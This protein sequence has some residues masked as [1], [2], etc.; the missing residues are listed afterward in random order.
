MPSSASDVVLIAPG[1]SSRRV[2]KELWAYRELLWVLAARDIKVR[3]K[4]TVLGV[5]WVLLQPLLQ[6]TVFT[7][8]LGRIARLPSEGVPYA[9]FAYA[10]LLPWTFFSA[11]LSN[12][13]SSV[14]GSSQ[15]VTKVYFPRL[16]IPLSSVVAG[17]VDVAI[18]SVFLFGLL[19]YYE[20]AIG[21][22]ILVMAPLFVL[23][24]MTSFGVGAWLAALTVSYRDFRY[25]VPFLLQAWMFASPVVY[26]A[27]LVPSGWRWL[28]FLNPMAGVVEGFRDA[29]LNRPF[30][31]AEM[32]VSL[33]GGAV[34][35]IVGVSVFLRM[36]RSF[37]DVI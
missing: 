27:E 23:L 3:Y 8:L 15:L 32:G 30:D 20:V 31:L 11:T 29:V 12:C 37:A 16:V 21:W 26:S 13:A 36:E 25:T 1:Y 19:I 33:L 24:L 6:L 14:V 28:Y 9:L 10:G 35:I 5:V 18:A 34:A 17:M 22:R 7:V 2:L 4:Q